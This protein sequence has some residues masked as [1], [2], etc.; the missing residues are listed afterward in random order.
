MTR[1]IKAERFVCQLY[2][3]LESTPRPYRL[4]PTGSGV[5]NVSENARFKTDRFCKFLRETHRAECAV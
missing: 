5:Q 2:T 4:R 1:Q 3:I